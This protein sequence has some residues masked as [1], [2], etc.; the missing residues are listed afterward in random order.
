MLSSLRNLLK[1]QAKRIVPAG[2][3]TGVLGASLLMGVPGII[4]LGTGYQYTPHPACTAADI[5]A[6]PAS[7]QVA[8]VASVVLTG[9]S[10]T[11]TH[12]EYQFYVQAPG[13]S[14]TAVT[15]NYVPWNGNPT[16]TYTWNTS[17]AG[18]GIW[19]IGVW[20]R[21]S[22]SANAYDAYSLATYDI[23]GTCNVVTI[24]DSANPSAPGAAVTWTATAGG[25]IGTMFEWWALA[26][27][28]STWV[29]IK[30]YSTSNTYS[31]TV[32]ATAASTQGVYQLGVW[33]KAGGSSN[34]YDTYA[35]A[36]H[37]LLASCPTA[38]LTASPASPATTAATVTLT[39]TGCGAGTE[40]EFWYLAPGS[41][42]WVVA[43][44]YSATATFSGTI[45][46]GTVRGAWRFGVW[47]KDP[48]STNSYDSYAIITYWITP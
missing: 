40:Y 39:A 46:A 36:T 4:G 11:C 12:P 28:S 15:A 34:A 9:T 29:M 26:P 48:K 45:S 30:A 42:T 2:A 3:V 31:W 18:P 43:Q 6:A 1:K 23:T 47:V 33:A 20:V 16:Q 14:W 7:P 41:S 27:G 22:G 32:G 19:G 13:G 8:G 37:T 38:T 17:A 5:S 10:T 44:A 24:A 21:E 25:C 35:V